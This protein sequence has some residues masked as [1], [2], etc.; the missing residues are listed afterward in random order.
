MVILM[1]D[2]LKSLFWKEENMSTET[3]CTPETK[4][5]KQR[6]ADTDFVRK[7][8]V[9]QS[10]GE[11]AVELDRTVA[12]VQ[13]RANKLRKAGVALKPY[14]KAKRDIDVAGLNSLIQ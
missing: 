4:V 5:V 2:F 12:S 10:Y 1:F 14:A 9:C 3:D 11:L 6:I 8:V 7:Y 13:Q